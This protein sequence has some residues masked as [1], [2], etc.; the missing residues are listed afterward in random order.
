MTTLHKKSIIKKTIQVGT[1]TFLSRVLGIAREVLMAKYYLGAGVI[2]DA[3]ITAFKIPNSMRKV[4]AEGALSAA[5]IPTFVGLIK[6]DRKDEVNR[7]MTLSFLVFEGVLLILCALIFWKAE[8]VIRIIAPGWYKIESIATNATSTVEALKQVAYGVYALLTTGQF[9]VQADQALYAPALLRI[10]I[11]FIF[12]LSSSSLLAAALQSVNHFF[13]PAFSPV[14]LNVIFITGIFVC[15]AKDLSVDY[16]CYFILFGGFVQ[17]ALHVVAYFKYHFS[18]G[19]IDALALKNFR[20]VLK[21]F[22][23][24]FFSMSVMEI[25][26]FIA[27]T[28][29]SYLPKGSISLIYYANRFMGVPLGIFALAFSTILLPHFSRIGT[30]APKR[31]SYYLLEA[32]KFIFWIT[33]PFTLFMS[34]VAE[35][36]FHTLFLSDKFSIDQVFE[37]KNILIAYLI[38][39]FFFSLNK[40]L[41]NMYYA[42]HE[43]TVPLYIAFFS[44]GT[45]YTVSKLCLPAYGAIGLAFATVISAMVQVLLS[46]FF[47]HKRFKFRL[48]ATNFLIFAMRYALQLVVMAILFLAGYYSI[49]WLIEQMLPASLA[50]FLL[51]KIGFWFWVCPLAFGIALML[52]FTRTLFNVNLYFLDE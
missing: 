48:Y 16:L 37:A 42:L 51:F 2:S 13:V 38:G 12:F 31:L 18:F 40:I 25:N 23:P 11:G 6:K 46:V 7:L 28:L 49:T 29:A 3:F 43:T 21:K 27:T 24:C 14:L 45:Y 1:S 15:M 47:L 41:L 52:F 35:K 39:L 19:A 44:V 17:F 4:F 8:L 5:L 20:A 10:L 9:A 32:S 26:L 34:F 50:T 36:I 33:I 22:L 30:Y